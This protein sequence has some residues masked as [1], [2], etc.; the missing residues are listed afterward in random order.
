M[1]RFIAL[2]LCFA[3]PAAHAAAVPA[4]EL[5]VIHKTQIVAGIAPKSDEHFQTS[6][7]HALAEA[8]GRPVR[9]LGLPRKRLASALEAGEGD[10]VCGYLPEWLPGA[11]DWS[12]G[13]IPVGDVVVSAP[14]VAPPHAI[15][16]LRGKRVGTVLGFRYPDF[17]TVLG[18]DFVRDDGLSESRSLQ[19]M[20]AGRFDHVITTRITVNNQI[21]SG[22][23]PRN[24]HVLVTKDFLTM[25][26]VS[27]HGH[28]TT[29][30]VN[31]AI[32]A[33][34]R[35]GTVDKLQRSR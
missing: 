8:M 10:I 3:V 7:G 17:D 16:D 33:I 35:N 6:L 23:L 19:K 12:R 20:L 1:L 13:F 9:F 26:A 24:V 22:A 28:V 34:E 15:E 27:R 4:R 14:G 18:K 25:C 11:F 31:A 21:R 32:D 5:V 30:D 2:I 29:A